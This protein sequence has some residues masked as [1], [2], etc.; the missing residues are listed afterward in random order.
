VAKVNK[1]HRN[2]KDGRGF[3]MSYCRFLQADA[4]I[5]MHV[6]GFLTCCGCSLPIENDIGVHSFEANSTQEMLDHIDAHLEAGHLIPGFVKERLI[7]DDKKNFP[8]LEDGV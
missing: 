8:D 2:S 6:G 3:V 5:F 7:E 4:Y 1:E